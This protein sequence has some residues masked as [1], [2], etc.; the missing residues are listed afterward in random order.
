[1]IK[2]YMKQKVFSV[3]DRF[4]VRD[5]S[6]QDRYYV[7]GEFFSIGK[8]LHICDMMGNEVSYIQ[9]KV[10]AFLPSFFVYVGRQ[11]VYGFAPALSNRRA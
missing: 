8:K 11:G 3:R 5:G 6:G 7:E 4:T 1:M 9:Q 10:L 2:L